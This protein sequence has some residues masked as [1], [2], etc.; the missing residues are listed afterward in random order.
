DVIRI[1]SRVSRTTRLAGSPCLPIGMLSE[2]IKRQLYPKK[3]I[4]NCPEKYEEDIGQHKEAVQPETQSC[5]LF[6]SFPYV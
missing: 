6:W 4:S 1:P 5:M 3:E 2:D